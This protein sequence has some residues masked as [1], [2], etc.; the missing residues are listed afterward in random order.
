MAQ[1]GPSDDA[2]VPATSLDAAVHDREFFRSLVEN[3]SDAIVSIDTD[4]TIRYANGSVER[5]LGYDPTA[6]IGE[7]LTTIMPE[8]FRDSHF[9]SMGAYLETG[10]RTIDWNGIELPAEHADGHEIPLS[11][12]FEEH[13][14][15]G[16]RL[17]SG[18]MRDVSDRVERERELERQNE[19]LERFAG[20]VSH[21]LRNPLQEARSAAVV[22]RD[23][24]TEALADVE[25]SLDR[26]GELIDDVLTLAKQGRAVGET[27]PVTL[28]QVARDAWGTAG[29]ETA[30]LSTPTESVTVAADRERLRTLFE[31]LFANAVEHGGADVSVVVESA[32]EGDGFVVRDD[33]DG[34]ERD[35]D[36]ELFDYGY[37][38]DEGGTGFGLSIVRDVAAAHGWDVAAT[39]A[40][41]GGAQFEIDTE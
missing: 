15:E 13:R 32:D 24:N 9:E 25:A 8:R 2:R 7:P 40:P 37:T 6:L 5:I 38:T 27:E 30:S 19:R 28:A 31:N 1:S 41:D 17:F 3:G 34:F 35:P 20:I 21:D 22:A 26:M 39:T 33:G 4:S 23:G 29:T 10:E 14:H 11:I 12:T 16:E 36:E 18:I